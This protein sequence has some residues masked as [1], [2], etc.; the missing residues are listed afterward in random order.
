MSVLFLDIDGTL[1]SGPEVN[2]QSAALGEHDDVLD[3]QV[4]IDEFRQPGFQDLTTPPG[5]VA[6]VG[7]RCRSPRPVETGAGV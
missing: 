3:M 5:V 6:V 1:A 2:H 4:P 7:R